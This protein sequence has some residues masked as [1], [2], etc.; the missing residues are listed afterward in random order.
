MLGDGECQEGEVWEAAFLAPRYALDN[1]IVIV[2]HNKL[3]QYGWPGEG[4]D[5]RLPPALPGELA[6]KWSA[7]GWR[8]LEVDGHD[9]AAVVAVLDRAVVGDGRPV[10]I[11]ADTI[12][13]RGVSFM[14]GRYY[15]HTRPMTADE[16]ATAM[17]E[18]GEPVTAPGGGA[19]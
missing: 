1:L 4:P 5:G 7:F 15:W 13:G 8:V 16:F 19:A 3:Q 17:A 9:M 14:E 18:L 2:D 10:A 6:A 11:I 12:K